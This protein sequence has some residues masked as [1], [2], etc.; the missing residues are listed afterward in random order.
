VAL[1]R[2]RRRRTGRWPASGH[3]APDASGHVWATL[4]RLWNRPNAGLLRAP[5]LLVVGLVSRGRTRPDAGR[6]RQVVA[7]VHPVMVTVGA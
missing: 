1:T 7:L 5:A 3:G 4:D 6:L 2:G